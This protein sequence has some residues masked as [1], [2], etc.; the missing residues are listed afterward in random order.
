MVIVNDGL[1]F[2]I[3]WLEYAFETQKLHIGLSKISKHFLVKKIFHPGLI[4]WAA[5]TQQ[6]CINAIVPIFLIVQEQR[7]YPVIPFMHNLS[8][9]GGPRDN[10]V[11]V[12]T[13]Y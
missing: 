2:C 13:N 7:K 5:E 1:W 11:P 10:T 6:T 3:A 4:P 8:C 9:P 12:S